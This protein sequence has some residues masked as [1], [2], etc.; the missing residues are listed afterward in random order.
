V[1]IQ[2]SHPCP[3]S[4]EPTSLSRQRHSGQ[5]ATWNHCRRLVR[6]HVFASAAGRVPCKQGMLPGAH[7][8]SVVPRSLTWHTI[9]P[10]KCAAAADISAYSRPIIRLGCS[11]FW[12]PSCALSQPYIRQ[13]CLHALSAAQYV[14]VWEQLRSGQRSSPRTKRLPPQKPLDS[15]VRTFVVHPPHLFMAQ[16]AKTKLSNPPSIDKRARLQP[17]FPRA[18]RQNRLRGRVAGSPIAPARAVEHTQT[19]SV[20]CPPVFRTGRRN[21]RVTSP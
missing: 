5:G 11:P 16:L 12:L 10:T 4:P 8:G 13:S 15:R 19:A 14:L 21:S 20:F 1:D 3:L 9:S 6:I 7:E 17:V 18:F 2:H